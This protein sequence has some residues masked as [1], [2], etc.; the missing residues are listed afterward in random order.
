MKLR[1]LGVF[2]CVAFAGQPADAGG[3][4]LPGSGAASTS[5]AGAAVASADDGEALSINPAGLAKSTGWT[6]TISAA[7]TRYYMTFQR[8]G[9]YDPVA[10]VDT[11]GYEGQRFGAVTNDPK[12]PLGLGSFQPIPVIAV[13][14]DLGGRVPG[15]HLAAGLYAP[16]GYPFRDMSQGYD[17]AKETACTGSQ[18]GDCV[19]PPPT[20]YDAMTA[21][22]TA[23]FPSIAAAYEILPQLDIGARFSAGS[24]SAKQSVVVWGS[25]GN[26]AESVRNDTLFNADV[27]DPFVPTFGVGVTYRPTPVLEFGAVYNSAATLR[28]QGSGLSTKGPSVDMVKVVGPIGNNDVGSRPRCTASGSDFKNGGKV[29]ACISVQLPQTA[30]VAARYKALDEYGRLRGDVEL[31][32]GWEN[33]GKTCDF[34]SHDAIERN[35]NCVS[36]SQIL[37]N[38]DAGLYVNDGFTVPLEINA[39]NL[40]LQDVYTARLGGSYV[41][42]IDDGSADPA[43]WPDR[44]IL[45]GGVGFDTRAAREGWL[46]ASF[47]GAARLT[48]TIGAAYHT[49]KWELSF[50]GGAVFEGSNTN[51]GAAA[52]GSVCNPTRQDPSGCGANGATRDPA[53]RQGPDPTNPLIGPEVQFESPINQGTIKSHYL[54][55]MLG[56]NRWW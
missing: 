55:F 33:W 4:F 24:A 42:P 48:T 27:K 43:G 25:P 41:M 10:A 9:D 56:F 12:P 29:P 14:T 11:Q 37:V 53:D 46:R 39:V 54:L 7:I 5:R 31:D 21:E 28:L 40:G 16:N 19:A 51:G 15:L 38:L 6:L 17:F 50:G 49:P 22:S 45:R 34:S 2:V 1:V 30:T 47:D 18:P 8:T 3:L 20:R 52:D 36:P 13:V 23:L 35:P 44:F 26:V 32:V